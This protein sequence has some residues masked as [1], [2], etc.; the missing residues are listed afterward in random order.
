M[1]CPSAPPR[2]VVQAVGAGNRG[3]AP[4]LETGRGAGGY[5]ADETPAFA[6]R[7]GQRLRGRR[8]VAAGRA[9]TGCGP[10][11]YQ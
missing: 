11:W 7:Q 4:V 2:W 3:V 1:Q 6:S 8:S 5:G 9:G 10:F